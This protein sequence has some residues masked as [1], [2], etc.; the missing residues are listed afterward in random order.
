MD[1]RSGR[2]ISPHPWRKTSELG[3]II[4]IS[5]S[6][7]LGCANSRDPLVFTFSLRLGWKGCG[8]RPLA[9][10]SV[11]IIGSLVPGLRIAEAWFRSSPP[12]SFHD[13]ETSRAPC[14][15]SGDPP[16]FSWEGKLELT[17]ALRHL[18]QPREF[19]KVST[20][21]NPE[22]S[23]QRRGSERVSVVFSRSVALLVFFPAAAGA[24]VVAA[25]F[26]FASLNSLR[27]G[28]FFSAIEDEWGLGA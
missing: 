9:V 5:C 22:G 11:S 25:D 20:Q 21:E 2:S 15:R 3:R 6:F 8:L 26:V 7:G 10:F 14:R 28:W 27:C 1:A 12:T 18:S 17:E 23:L 16:R 24:G 19:Q 4:F 13:A